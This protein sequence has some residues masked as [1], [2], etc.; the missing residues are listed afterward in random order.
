[1]AERQNAR[2]RL[3]NITQQKKKEI[4]H[5]R[6]TADFPAKLYNFDSIHPSFSTPGVKK[7]PQQTTSLTKLSSTDVATRAAAVAA[8]SAK[9]ALFYF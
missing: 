3:Q 8:V 7:K 5:P 6:G 4:K 2:W 1:M 9:A